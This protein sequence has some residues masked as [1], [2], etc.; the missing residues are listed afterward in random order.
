VASNRTLAY[1]G[2]A[3]AL[4]YLPIHIYWAL[5]GLN[6]SIGIDGTQPGFRAAN[7]GACVVIVGA[8][9]TCLSLVHRWG[10]P[11][12]RGL[13]QGTAWV[14]GVFGILHWVVFSVGSVLRLAGA[15]DYPTGLVSVGKLRHFDW[16]NVGYFE[17]WFGVM[18]LLLIA[19]ARRSRSRERAAAPAAVS[20][21]RR[22]GMALTVIGLTTVLWGVLNFNVWV[23][24]GYGPAVFVLGLLTLRLRGSQSAVRPS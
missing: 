23:F 24:A 4:S 13:R 18:G 5:G 17:P 19:C 21:W 10:H 12:P 9:L 7:W 15:V 22:A 20:S 8:A 14:G 16:A 11:L 2:F 6:P 3:W 1:V